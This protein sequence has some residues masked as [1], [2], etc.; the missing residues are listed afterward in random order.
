MRWLGRYLT[1]NREWI[2]GLLLAGLVAWSLDQRQVAAALI[3]IAVGPVLVCLV[4][5]TG[6]PVSY[7]RV[8]AGPS[9]RLGWWW[10]CRR[11]WTGIAED[12]GLGVRVPVTVKRS[13]GSRVR[14]QV[15]RVPRLRRV[16]VHGHVLVLTIR[17]RAGQTVEDLDAAAPRIASTLSA[18][19]HRTRPVS[20]VGFGCSTVIELVMADALPDTVRAAE[21]D[22]APVYEGV[23]LGRSQI[24]ADWWLQL[25]GRHTLIA[26]CSDAGKGSVM[27]G[28]CCGLAP[29]VRSD[30]VR[31]W[32]LD[33]KRG[34]ELKMG[35]DLFSTYA[36]TPGEALGVLH[37]LMAV[38]DERGGVMAGTTRLHQPRP[39]DPLH[40]L[41]IDELAVLTAY[42]EAS[43]RK[44]ADRLL[45]EILTQGRALG[46]VVVACVQD[47]RKEVVGMRG[48][49][50]QTIAL[51]LR[52]VEETVMVLGEGMSK[53]APAHRI[54]PAFPGTAWIVEETGAVDR[55]RADYWTDW[56]IQH[57][58]AAY[59]TRFHGT[60]KSS[61]V[62]ENPEGAASGPAGAW[63]VAVPGSVS[64]GHHANHGHRETTR[65]TQLG[66]RM[67]QMSSHLPKVRHEHRRAGVDGRGDVCPGRSTVER[68]QRPG[69]SGSGA[70]D[71]G[72]LHAM[73]GTARVCG[74]CGRQ[75]DQRRM[76]GR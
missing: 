63:M 15:T 5:R 27:W 43:V 47:P 69:A 11:R 24:G 10:H 53:V 52:S 72:G 45:A 59:A 22:P 18:V 66:R 62:S 70:V 3:G 2:V 31:L 32:G 40:V 61:D 33:L 48:L 41:V 65:A 71:D 54:N 34:V 25:R 13:D 39:G 28:I 17:A 67:S 38:I 75:W 1:R 29:A 74:V 4:W 64:R 68:G 35:A 19:T 23:R 20:G 21:P 14:E 16:R 49:F 37:A 60:P 58:A 12:C 42:A 46:V 56:M 26:G 51:R 6:W 50:T 44:V 36:Y 7:E 57:V 8:C 73:P 9:R 76:V 55:V 30:V